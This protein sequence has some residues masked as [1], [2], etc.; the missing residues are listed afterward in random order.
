[1]MRAVAIKDLKILPLK[2]EKCGGFIEAESYDV[3]F[4]CGNCSTGFELVDDN[5]EPIEVKFAAAKGGSTASIHKPFWVL[6]TEISF[7]E[8]RT[9]NGVV[10]AFSKFFLSDRGRDVLRIHFYVP[11]FEID[12]KNLKKLG[13]KYTQQQPS[14]ATVGGTKL[15]GCRLCRKDAEKLAEYLFISV[16]AGKKDTLQNLRYS[17]KFH[18][19]FILGVPFV[20][21]EDKMKDAVL[22]IAL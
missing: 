8:R 12:L 5:L 16:E 6:D 7:F 4:Y 18:D 2:C 1:M 10:D 20:K 22:G 14:L 21:E 15:T 13:I 19:A 11:A 9:A 3:V 17:M